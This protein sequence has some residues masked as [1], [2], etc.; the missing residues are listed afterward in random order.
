MTIPLLKFNCAKYLLFDND[1]TTSLFLESTPDPQCGAIIEKYKD[2]FLSCIDARA[3]CQ[4]DGD[5]GGH[6]QKA[7]L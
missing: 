4:K 1:S 2:R 6:P 7:V 5:K 3:I